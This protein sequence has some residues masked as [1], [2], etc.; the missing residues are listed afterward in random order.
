M[1]R[2]LSGTSTGAA[3]LSAQIDA[4]ESTL[5]PE[6]RE[7]AKSGSA[8]GSS[9]GGTSAPSSQQQFAPAT[10]PAAIANVAAGSG[11]WESAIASS[12]LGASYEASIPPLQQTQELARSAQDI[13]TPLVADL[14]ELTQRGEELA[15]QADTANT[16]TL[17]A[18]KTAAR[19]SDATIQAAH[20]F[21]DPLGAGGNPA[22]SLPKEP[23]ELARQCGE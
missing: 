19:R 14:R 10:P 5:P 13:R 2:F 15:H 18:G 6:L 7:A 9:S 23:C 4:L 20:R 11:L 12:P 16:A 22:G 21:R 8:N 1:T 3:G 17:R